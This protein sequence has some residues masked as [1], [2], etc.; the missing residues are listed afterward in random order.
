MSL[1]AVSFWGMVIAYSE[2]SMEHEAV[3]GEIPVFTTSDVRGRL[4]VGV[5]P[6][7]WTLRDLLSIG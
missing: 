5:A 2:G 7:F 4:P 3:L 1:E 6:L